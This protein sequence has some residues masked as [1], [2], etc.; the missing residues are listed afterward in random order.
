MLQCPDCRFRQAET[1]S[2]CAHCGR[3][4]L[5]PPPRTFK[6]LLPSVAL[7]AAALLLITCVTWPRHRPAPRSAAVPAGAAPSTR[8]PHVTPPAS[9]VS[10]PAANPV[11]KPVPRAIRLTADVFCAHSGGPLPV[12][13]RIL[14]TALADADPGRPVTLMLSCRRDRNAVSFLSVAEGR[15]C[16]IAWTPAVPGRYQFTATASDDHVRAV[17]SRPLLLTVTAAP[18]GA[19]LP[20]R[21]RPAGVRALPVLP[22]GVEPLPVLPPMAYALP[23]LRPRLRLARLPSLPD[24]PAVPTPR[25]ET[26]ALKA[27][28]PALCHVVVATFPSARNAVVLAKSFWGRGL[29]VAVRHKPDSRGRETYVVEMAASH[30]QAIARQSVLSLQ[31]SGYPAYCFN[32]E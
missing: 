1:N 29:R 13:S 6:T 18:P 19:A 31:R 14:L 22:A 3:S 24:R 26:V 20:P 16:S 27:A 12:G 5:P 11:P 10:G 8:P 21:D 15:L 9:R 2:S 7:S 32:G 17:V 4:L 23:P 30:N 28:S 25:P